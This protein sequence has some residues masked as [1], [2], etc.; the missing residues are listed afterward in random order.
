MRYVGLF[1]VLS[2][3]IAWAA[4]P[5]TPEAPRYLSARHSEG[6]QTPPDRWSEVEN[7]LW[8]TELPGLGWSSPIVTGG[9]VY[10]TTCVSSGAVREPRKGLYLE[11]LNANLYPKETAQHEWKVYCLD[12]ST[13]SVLWERVAHA[14]VPP[15]P[16]HLKNSLASETPVTDGQRL[17]AYFG[18]I[19][20]YCYDLDGKPL[21][22]IEM[23][24]RETQ[25]GWGT[26]ISPIVH[27]GRLYLVNDNE[28]ESNLVCYD[29]TSGK[30][31][32]RV[33]RDEK[34][35]YSTPYIWKNKLR[36]ELVMSGINWARSYDLSGKPLWQ[37]KGLSILAIPTPFA[38][39]GILYLTSGH[40]VWGKNPMYAIRPGANG[41]ISPPADGEGKLSEH[42]EWHNPK[43][44][45]YHPTPIIVGDQMY[46]LYDRGFFAS[47]DVKTGREVYSRKRLPVADFTSSPWSYGGKIFCVNEDGVTV[48]IDAGPEFKVS[49]ENRLAE[50][51]MCMASPVVLGDKLLIRTAARLYCIGSK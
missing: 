17:F 20:L 16:H 18:N 40:V 33:A 29:C 35:N 3:Q 44:G 12:Q 31:L 37:I 36:T 22:Q 43:G 10:L 13:G 39:D 46:V 32:W 42:L 21:W 9:R 23:P 49:H 38:H 19:G 48:A 28:E 1:F 5:S 51:D 50:D 15:K 7:V 25:Q 41:D 24:A 34:T 2:T 6:E 11:D 14:G 4:A 8:K 45:P 26:S 47:Y 27:E 30:E